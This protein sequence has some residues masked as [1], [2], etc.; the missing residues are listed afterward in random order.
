MIFRLPAEHIFPDPA[1]AEED[2]LIA[3]GGDLHPDRIIKAYCQGIFP[4]FSR[5]QPILW[6]SP[7]PR[8]VL[9]PKELKVA[10]SLRQ[11]CKKQPYAITAN[12][13][14]KQVLDAC[15]KAKRPD[16][17]GTWITAGMA[18]AYNQ[19]HKLGVAWS[20]EAW[21]GDKLAGGLYGL[22]LGKVFFGESMFYSEKDASKVAFVYWVDWLIQNGIELIDCQMATSH[23]QRFGAREIPRE[24]YLKL[25]DELIPP[26]HE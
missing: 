15:A 5:R 6:W 17:E 26:I 7:D 18:K 8:M 14:F 21:L 3:I 4:W 25:L 11:T 19:L 13:S 2:G 16:Q 12:K 23:L 9:F 1:L 22:L 10:R 20:V 24:E